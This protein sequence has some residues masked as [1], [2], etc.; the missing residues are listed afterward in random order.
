QDW[1]DLVKPDVQIVTPNPKTSGNGRL[2]FLAAWGSVLERGG[3]EQDALNFVRKLYQQVTALD[4]GARGATISFTEKKLGDVLITWENEALLAAKSSN[5]E[6]Q[7][8]YPP[9]SIRAEP[10]VAVVSANAKRNGTQAAAE[11]YLRY[12]YTPEAQEV[13]ARHG[14]R[15]G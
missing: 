4:E 6:L 5:G 15:P 2:S 9:L 1:N 7:V 10:H 13:I 14:Y 8:V 12:L 3:S 11:A